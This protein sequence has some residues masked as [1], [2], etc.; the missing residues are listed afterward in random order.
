[1]K[2]TTILFLLCI[3]MSCTQEEEALY[4]NQGRIPLGEYEELIA[5]CDTESLTSFEQFDP[6]IARIQQIFAD[7]KDPRGAFPTVYKAI[8]TAAV[9]S[10]A[11][12]IYEDEEYSNIFGVDFSK[13]YLYYLKDHLLNR[14]LEYHWDLYYQ[15]AMNDYHITRLVLEGI[16]AHLTLDLTRAL[17]HTGVQPEFAD[18]WILFGD[19]TVLSVPGFLEELQDEYD[20]D[21]SGVFNVFFIG[22]ILDLIFG[23]GT[24]I[25]FGFN[26]LRID[27]FNNAMAM[28]IP[29]QEER[30]EANLERAFWEREQIMALLDNLN[31]TPRIGVST[32]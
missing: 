23:E 6:V 19:V 5:L 2:K 8:T 25:N 26:L 32:K 4:V 30:I 14:P 17:G 24:T 13:R 22:D 10:L 15:H 21:A 28:Q 27:A 11:D 20:T 16:N 1:M 31:L 9:E 3:I 18:D 29:G 12:G 7:H